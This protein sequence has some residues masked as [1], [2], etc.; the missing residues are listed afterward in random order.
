M[1]PVNCLCN[2]GLPSGLNGGTKYVYCNKRWNYKA[3]KGDGKVGRN[4]VLEALDLTRLH[5]SL[6]EI[7]SKSEFIREVLTK[8][9]R[10]DGTDLKGEECSAELSAYKCTG[11]SVERRNLSIYGGKAYT[12]GQI[13]EGH[14]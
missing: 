4:L 6:L 2:Q 1:L 5:L 13:P 9:T 10:E 7:L 8:R 3:I 11:L 14:H 12:L